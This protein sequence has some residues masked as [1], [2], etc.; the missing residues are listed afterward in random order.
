MFENDFLYP[1]FLPLWKC[2]DWG[3]IGTLMDKKKCG[4]SELLQEVYNVEQAGAFE[5]S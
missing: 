5:R 4:F 3:I 2:L 1:V